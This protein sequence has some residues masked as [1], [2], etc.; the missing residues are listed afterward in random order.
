MA[1]SGSTDFALNRDQLIQE[2]AEL[3]GA[4]D[5]AEGLEPHLINSFS[6][7]L[8][9]MLKSWQARGLFLHAYKSATLFLTK[10]AQSYL[11]GPTGAHCAESTVSTTLSADAALGAGTLTLY[12]TAGITNGDYIG[13]ELDDGT[14]QWTTVTDAAATTITSVLTGA[15]S[16]GNAVYTYTTKILRPLAITDI[17]LKDSSGNEIPVTHLSQEDY[18]RLPNKTS[19]GKCVQVAFDPQLTNAVL[20]TWPVCA[21]VTTQLLFR[22]KRPIDDLDAQ[23]D[24]AM[25]A[26]DWYMA[27]VS[28]LAYHIAPKLN[29]PI[30]KQVALKARYDEALAGLDDFEEASFFLQPARR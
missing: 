1:F 4:V 28:G 25:V 11:L 13:I 30:D 6:R 2:A 18:F 17:R 22:Y 20:Y 29:I 8:N 21:D 15:A 14:L 7:S 9:L 5:I 16:S 27:L 10:N 19:A 3:T 23:T 24:N 26:A 12:S